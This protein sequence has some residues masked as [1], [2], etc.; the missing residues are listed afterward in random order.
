MPPV[1]LLRLR[2]V[3]KVFDIATLSVPNHRRVAH[4]TMRGLI[5]KAGLTVEE[6]VALLDE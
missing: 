2:D 6:F 3:V 4:G 5:V 1:P